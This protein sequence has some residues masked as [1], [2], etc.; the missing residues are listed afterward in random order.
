MEKVKAVSRLVD[1][2]SVTKPSCVFTRSVN[3]VCG[4]EADATGYR[5][6]TTKA[7]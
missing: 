1:A 3:V 5:L 7:A 2:E 4:S 6:V